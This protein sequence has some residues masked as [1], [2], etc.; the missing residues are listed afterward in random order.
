MAPVIDP[1]ELR[2]LRVGHRRAH[3]SPEMPTPEFLGGRKHDVAEDACDVWVPSEGREAQTVFTL[4]VL[5]LS[6][7]I[8]ETQ[9]LISPGEVKF[10]PGDH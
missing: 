1:T 4:T 5:K 8:E 9:S 7:L 2:L 6:S 10:S 3:G